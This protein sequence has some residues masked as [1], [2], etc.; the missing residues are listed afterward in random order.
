MTQQAYEWFHCLNEVPGVE[1]TTP[2]GTAVDA[3]LAAAQP[4]ADRNSYSPL[5]VIWIDSRGRPIGDGYMSGR[6]PA[7]SALEGRWE[8]RDPVQV[9]GKACQALALPGLRS[10]YHEALSWLAGMPGIDGDL[11][12]RTIVADVQ[13][14]LADPL[15][16]LTSPWSIDLERDYVLSQACGPILRLVQLYLGEGFIVEAAEAEKLLDRLPAE[17]QPQHEYW[18]KPAAVAV[19]LEALQAA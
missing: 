3:R 9:S 19:A 15:A 2:E 6:S 5:G 4:V 10:D 12:E 14:V 1:W 18:T 17:A 13:L 8:I 16:A 11:L 7:G